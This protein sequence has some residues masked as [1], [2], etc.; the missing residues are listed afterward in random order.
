MRKI[1]ENILCR[2]SIGILLFALLMV[3]IMSATVNRAWAYFTTYATAKGGY[4]LS[5]RETV[6]D[7]HFVNKRKI[8]NIKNNG[9]QDVW[10]RL[11]VMVG[12]EYEDLIRVEKDSKWSDMDNEG[13][14]YYAYPLGA[15]ETTG[16]F[17]DSTDYE[18]FVVN[19]ENLLEK[20]FEDGKTVNVDIV[21]ESLPVQHNS[22]GSVI[23]WS[24]DDWSEKAEILEA[25]N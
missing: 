5:F 23:P 24:P 1:K 7:E 11:K 19:V 4:S 25:D 6:P 18:A 22:D 8:V 12:S 21:Y 9:T 10:I 3:M 17:K 13:W 15:G 16:H 20:D 14:Y 2:S